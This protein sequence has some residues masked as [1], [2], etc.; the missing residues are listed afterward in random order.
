MNK[1]GQAVMVGMMLGIMLFIAMVQLIGP[2]KDTI[3]TARDPTN[4]DCGNSSIT[5]GTK[6]VCI[7]IDF[8]LFYIVGV[9]MAAAIGGVVGRIGGLAGKK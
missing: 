2:L 3:I 6:S 7:L 5:T 4:L 1:K 8:S 9:V